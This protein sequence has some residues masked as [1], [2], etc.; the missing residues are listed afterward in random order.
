MVE[1]WWT[2]IIVKSADDAGIVEDH[3][4]NYNNLFGLAAVPTATHFG[5]RESLNPYIIESGAS[6]FGTEVGLI[7]SGDTPVRVGMT[8]Y[9]PRII[10]VVDTSNNT[11]SCLRLIWKTPAQSIN[12]AITAM[13][14]SDVVIHQQTAAGQNKPQDGWMIRIATGN[15]LWG[16]VKNATN[17]ATVSI[18]VNM[19]EYPPLSP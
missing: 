17:H 1:Y 4:H 2:P 3:F 16:M 9:D 18:L 7:G 12:D 8:L 11:P 15:E 10:S 13:Q 19:H 5:D 6:A 14:Y